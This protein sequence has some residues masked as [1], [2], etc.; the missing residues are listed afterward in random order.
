M[1]ASTRQ[2]KPVPDTAA[3]NVSI[4]NCAVLVCV[5]C[6]VLVCC[7]AAVRYLHLPYYCASSASQRLS[8]VLCVCVCASFLPVG[9]LIPPLSPPLPPASLPVPVPV[10]AP[11]SHFPVVPA[12]V[13]Y[14]PLL[15][16]TTLV[17]PHPFSPTSLTP[18]CPSTL[19]TYSTTHTHLSGCLCL[20][21]S[22]LFISSRTP[23]STT[24]TFLHPSITTLPRVSIQLD[25]SV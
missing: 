8:V 2:Y 1:Q 22:S 25:H 9:L 13:L 4:F 23:S 15:Q 18:P 16:Y 11:F 10:P 5:Y 7:P 24:F 21:L 3:G 6:I 12:Q 20:S 17:L 14:L 19:S